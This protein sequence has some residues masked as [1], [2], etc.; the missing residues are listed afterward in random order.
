[1]IRLSVRLVVA[2]LVLVFAALF[3]RGTLGSFTG[4]PDSTFKHAEP[5]L[6]ME[7]QAGTSGDTVVKEA[8]FVPDPGY[9]IDTSYHQPAPVKFAGGDHDVADSPL[10]VTDIPAAVF[11]QPGGGWYWSIQPPL[12]LYVDVND[13][14]PDGRPTAYTFSARLY[15]GPEPHPGPGCNANMDVW[16]KQKPIKSR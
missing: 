11:L 12:K 5:K 8:R 1:M 16:I 6:Y 9:T 13:F 7:R 2:M 10:K 15:C 4:P 3:V 14:G